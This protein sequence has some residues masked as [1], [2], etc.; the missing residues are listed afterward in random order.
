MWATIGILAAL[1]AREAT[2]HGQHVDVSLLDGQLAWLTYVA[3]PTR[4]CPPPTAT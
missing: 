1:H 3:A 4:H 2:G